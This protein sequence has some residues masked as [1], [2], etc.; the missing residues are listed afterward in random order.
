VSAGYKF[1]E[2][3][4]YHIRRLDED[5][6]GLSQLF[7]PINKNQNHWMFVRVVFEQKRIEVWDSLGADEDSRQYTRDI[8]RYLYDLK[9]RIPASESYSQN[10]PS[11]DDWKMEWTCHDMTQRSPQQTNLDDCGIFTMV[12][13]TLLANGHELTRSSYNQEV[14]TFQQTRRRIAL[15]IME[16]AEGNAGG[17]TSFLTRSSGRTAAGMRKGPPQPK[18]GTGKGKPSKGKA[19]SKQAGSTQHTV[20]KHPRQGISNIALCRQRLIAAKLGQKRDAKSL[21]DARKREVEQV[22]V[23]GGEKKRKRKD[24]DESNVK[25]FR[26]TPTGVSPTHL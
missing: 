14:I 1:N 3:R 21:A 22:E 23:G 7:I 5:I 10:A 13:I 18:R 12:S 16:D 2:V 8:R 19:E 11:F 17:I 26:E 24:G 20:A 9:Y 15:M 25:R 4:R 6:W